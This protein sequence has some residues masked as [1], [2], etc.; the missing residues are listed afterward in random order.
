MLFASIVGMFLFTV[1][2]K[3]TKTK[4]SIQLSH[5]EQKIKEFKDELET[6]YDEKL[7]ELKNEIDEIIKEKKRLNSQD[8]E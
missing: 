5:E 3:E 6:Y 8:E 2:I 7:E 1:V 4:T